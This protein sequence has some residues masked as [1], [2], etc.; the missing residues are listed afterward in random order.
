[1]AEKTVHVIAAGNKK[2][3]EEAKVPQSPTAFFFAGLHH[4]PVR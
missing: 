1:M 4:V 2:S 3:E